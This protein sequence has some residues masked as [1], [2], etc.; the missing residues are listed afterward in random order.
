MV[1]ICVM[2]KKGRKKTDDTQKTAS[3]CGGPA[4]GVSTTD[5]TPMHRLIPKSQTRFAAL[6]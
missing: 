4:I 2:D 6:I 1:P 5:Q 3:P